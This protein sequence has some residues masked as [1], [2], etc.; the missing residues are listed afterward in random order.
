MLEKKRYVFIIVILLLLGLLSVQSVAFGSNQGAEREK[1]TTKIFAGYIVL[2][3]EHR[4][5]FT[6]V[7]AFVPTDSLSPV[8]LVTLAESDSAVPGQTVYCG[9]RIVDGVAGV[10]LHIFY[11]DELP[12]QF[13]VTLTVY[14]DGAKRYGE[15][16]LYTGE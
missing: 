5:N 1:G 4:F 12:D 11:P 10:N 13:L 3:E 16:V 8:C 2:T 14:Q 7:R 9:R 6:E 15:P